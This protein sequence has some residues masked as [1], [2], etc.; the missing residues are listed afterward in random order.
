VTDPDDGTRAAADPG[1]V[2]AHVLLEAATGYLIVASFRSRR[3]P[4]FAA[5]L[6]DRAA[7]LLS[8]RRCPLVE[9][10]PPPPRPAEGP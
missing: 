10:C 5:A 3:H 2:D 6:V 7:A 9:G 8:L 1:A 4:R